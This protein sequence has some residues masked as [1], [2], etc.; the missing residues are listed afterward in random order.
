MKK[1]ITYLFAF[2]MLLLNSQKIIG[3]TFSQN[4]NLINVVPLLDDNVFENSEKFS[5]TLN[6]YSIESFVVNDEAIVNLENEKNLI[7]SSVS[8]VELSAP[9]AILT[10]ITQA[11][12]QTAVD[13]WIANP[14]TATATYGHISNWDTSN[15]T[16]MSSLFLNKTTFNDDI[17]GWD[18]SNVVSIRAMFNNAS[19]FNQ[20]IA[21]W[22]VSNVTGFDQVFSGATSF[23]QDIS[24]WNVAAS[25]NFKEM[26]KD[27][28]NFNQPLNNW[29]VTDTNNM[30]S[31]FRGATSFNQPLNN[32]NVTNITAMYFMFSGATNFN[33]DLTNW[34]ATNIASEP[35][36]FADNSALLNTNKPS[37]GTCTA[38]TS[39][40]TKVA[41]SITLNSVVLEGYITSNVTVIERGFVFAVTS[42]NSNPEINGTGVVKENNDAG[43]GTFSETITGLTSNTEYSYKAYAITAS[44]IIYGNVLT[45]TTLGNTP[46]VFTSVSSVN[47]T[48]NTDG[49][50]YTAEATDS[51]SITY[52][53]GVN[54]DESLF[55]IVGSTGE[56]SFVTSPDFETKASY[57]IN[58]IATDALGNAANKDVIIT[59]IDLDEVPPTFTSATAV[60][61][62]ENEAGVAYTITA[63]DNG[64]ITYN[65]GSGNDEASFTIDGAEV[66]F[67]A[68]PDFETKVSYTINVIAT[69]DLGNA[70]NQD[71]II[72]IIDLDEVP[73]TVV[74]TSSLMGPTSTTPIPVTVTFSET[75]TGFD[76][77]D[78][79]VS[80]GTIQSFTGTDA[81][82]SFDLVPSGG[83]TLTVDIAADV[84][85][86]A[87]G[88]NNTIANQFSIEYSDLPA[89]A[90]NF[91]GVD[92]Y[93]IIGNVLPSNTSYTKEAWIFTEQNKEAQNIISSL[94]APFWL[95]NL[96][97]EAT[98]LFR[99]SGSVQS[100]NTLPLNTWVHVAVSWDGTT[101]RLYENGVEV[102]SRTNVG[103]YTREAINL[104]AMVVGNPISMLDG[105]LDEV[106][107]WNTARS[108]A[109]IV[110]YKDVELTGN[111]SGL[112][113][114]YNFNQGNVNANNSGVTTLL[115][116]QTN[117]TVY[118]GTL[119][120]FTLTGST[121]NWI[122]GLANDVV[123][124]SL[125]LS[126]QAATDITTAN[127][128]LSG[129]VITVG[130]KSISEKGIMISDVN[131]NPTIPGA[132]TVKYIDTSAGNDISITRTD[133]NIAT[134]Y[135]FRTYA[136]D[137]DG[138][139]FYGDVF[140]FNTSG[141]TAPEIS[142]STATDITLNS[143]TL[144]GTIT[145]N[146]TKSIIETG[147]VI[148]ISSENA[149]P[150]ISGTDT[151]KLESGSISDE[152]ISFATGLSSNVQYSFK[153]YLIDED[154]TE[155]YGAV[156]TFTTPNIG[157]P[158]V[159]TTP[160]YDVEKNFATFGGNVLTNNGSSITAMG[161][162][163]SP[164][165]S[166]SNPQ[167]NGTDVQHRSKTP[168]GVG[169]FTLRAGSFSSGVQYS[170]RMYTTNAAGTAYSQVFT[171]YPQSS[172]V[173]T[174]DAINFTT[175][176][177]MLS[178]IVN[179]NYGSSITEKGVVYS[180]ASINNK[181]LING[182][183]V[184]KEPISDEVGGYFV[185]TINGLDVSTEY[186]FRTYAIN[187]FGTSYG[188]VKTFTTESTFLD[189]RIGYWTFEGGSVSDSEGNFGDLVFENADVSIVNGK[190]DVK[191]NGWARTS[192][193]VGSTIEE[194]TL[195]SF[196]EMRDLSVT[197]GA[198]IAIDGITNDNFDAIGFAERESGRWLAGS[199]SFSRTEDATPGFEETVTNIPV[200]M[201]IT[202]VRTP[203][204]IA[205]VKIYRNGEEIGAYYK[206]VFV[207]WPANNTEI[208]FGPRHSPTS[209]IRRG[210]IDALIDEAMLFNRALSPTEIRSLYK[211]SIEK[212]TITSTP[213]TLIDVTTV[214]LGGNITSDGKANVTER[215]IVYA[216]T[217]ANES[218]EIDGNEV[219]KVVGG[220]GIG[221][222][223]E[224]ITGLSGGTEY[225]YRSYAI[226]NQ[227]TAYG[228]VLTFSTLA[229]LAPSVTTTDVT[230]IEAF[231]A[232]FGSAVTNNG[233][234]DI[235][236]I[237]VL[238][239]ET[240]LNSNPEVTTTDVLKIGVEDAESFIS[241]IKN[242][243]PNTAYSYR[244]YANNDS[245]FGYGVTKTFTT[246]VVL[247][248]I[249]T[250]TAYEI[251]ETAA[252][253][254]IGV[255]SNGGSLF[256]EYG[257]VLSDVTLN[258]DPFVGGSNV[259]KITIDGID[260]PTSGLH[261]LVLTGLSSCIKYA[262]KG[263]AINAAG[264]T[265]GSLKTFTTQCP[266]PAGVA[267]ITTV[268]PQ[269]ITE[270]A[271][272]LAGNVS[273]NNGAA[274]TKR[275]IVYAKTSVNT[276][277]T[278][279][280]TDL[281]DVEL[282]NGIGAFNFKAIGLTP[283]TSYTYRAY[284]INSVGTVYGDVN[285]FTTT[286][287]PSAIPSGLIGHWDFENGSLEDKTG[288]WAALTLN[289][290][291]SIV[292]GKLDLNPGSLASTSTYA[293]ETIKQKTLV[294]FVELQ[295]L[296][297]RA[298]S[299][300]TIDGKNTTDN[301]D[302][303]VF[304][305]R[306]VNRWMAGS[307]WFRRTVNPT[308]GFEETTVG[309]PIMMAITYTEKSNG[310][311][312]I[313][314]YRNAVEIASYIKGNIAQWLPNNAEVL[315]G[316]RHT[317]PAMRG[318][319]DALVDEAMIFN[320][321]L[322]DAE[323]MTLYKN[324]VNTT[325]VV[326]TPVHSI[327]TNSAV[328][329]GNVL[330]DGGDTITDRGI[331]VAEK[332]INANPEIGGTGVTKSQI[333]EG[334]GFFGAKVSG[335][336]ESTTYA[337]KTYAKNS[338]GTVY[339]NVEEFSTIEVNADIAPDFSTAN[340]RLKFVQGQYFVAPADGVLLSISLRTHYA[341]KGS[342]LGRINISVYESN[343]DGSNIELGK[344][345]SFETQAGHMDVNQR[346]K[347]DMSSAGISLIR[348]KRYYYKFEIE[349]SAAGNKVIISDYAIYSFVTDRSHYTPG[350][351]IS[352]GTP[353]TESTTETSIF[354]IE[355]GPLRQSVD[356]IT[357]F[358]AG[359]SNDF[360]NP[361]N[362]SKGK[363][364]KNESIAVA[365]GVTLTVDQNDVELDDFFL[366]S[367]AELNIPN[368]KEV[369]VNS[370]F[371]TDGSLSLESSA[372][373]SGVLFLKGITTGTVT[374]KRGGL[375]A[376]KWSIIS[377][378]VSG[379][380]VIEFAQNTD[381]D[382]R[383]NNSVSPVR[384]AIGYYDDSMANKWQY[385]NA[386]TPVADT[387]EI[388][389]S[390]SMSRATDG[391]VTFT[392]TLEVGNVNQNVNVGEWQ[393]IGNPYTTYLAANKN[394][395][396]S[397]LEDNFDLLDDVF[398]GLYIWDNTQNK[399]VA[400][401]QIDTDNRSIPPGQGFFIR[402]KTSTNV[403]F[404]QN[405]R[406]LKP[407]EGNT[408]FNKSSNP[409]LVLNISDGIS[410]V[411]T[412]IKYFENATRA[413][414]AGYDFGNFGSSQLDIFTHLLEGNEGVDYTIQSLP[415]TDVDNISIPIGV[416]V[417]AG[418]E[419]VFSL[420]KIDIKD[421]LNIYL[422]DK[423]LNTFTS[424]SKKDEDYKISVSEDISGVGRF[425]LITSSKALN[426]DEY[427]FN[428][429][430]TVYTTDRNAL[431]ISGI[432]LGDKATIN[433][434][435]TL[436][437][438]VG[439]FKIN[440]AEIQNTFNLNNLPKGVY[441]VRLQSNRTSISK[442]IVLK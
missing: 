364:S 440:E 282:G 387:F 61:F 433:L 65:L 22:D 136:I 176:S 174:E 181:P 390:Y 199:T 243:K 246:N 207:G 226:N 372:E 435:N 421:G 222:F 220:T 130:S 132:A 32:W 345:K 442:K 363:P 292:D 354:G 416:S 100:P 409:E 75:I 438:Q 18:T 71:V 214:T 280:G 393:A 329:G 140:T 116:R 184:T 382:I 396:S 316:A 256:T 74:I 107:I 261:R 258:T 304:S 85:Q 86:D 338:S 108:S 149:D 331:V 380:R 84:A 343:S 52:S 191:S 386:D 231:K 422:E 81:D 79:S 357:T 95:N 80:G 12:I 430:I 340:Q 389:R 403:S 57:T 381:N 424:L 45:F 236:D 114:Y 257:I 398:K 273:A 294:S 374:Y 160:V 239:I 350:G 31:M 339:G 298:G 353:L 4:N 368:D 431:K 83:G 46:P 104:G 154:N 385:Y 275:G 137:A 120:D 204:G 105:N 391:E 301:F 201:A 206:G 158:T 283:S 264:T 97:L 349:K 151:T 420:S 30:Q 289:S 414:D 287:I 272:I 260:S 423:L 143:A 216:R 221:I 244:G 189:K 335:F 432:P 378:P 69:D 384:Y 127:A 40:D 271:A 182:T 224:N 377:A 311:V 164:T 249:T 437:K 270:N 200:M 1:T 336:E 68:S 263:Y 70:A 325:E 247:G 161:I 146:G 129:L 245:E 310:T 42:T 171:F 99:Y 128:T 112:V 126:T 240:A 101:M 118:N 36:G 303:I 306:Q 426:T 266:P 210:N 119:T 217:F 131:T 209:T 267:S 337:Y 300:L 58:V 417:K 196:V 92:D 265:Y 93:V 251:R 16:S 347:I 419:V 399:Y 351:F 234:A 38:N 47:F 237:G 73:P 415:L 167:L 54:A 242:L 64:V 268:A 163:F 250:T 324:S 262:Y 194:K 9:N 344:I 187:A 153:A 346:S 405:K 366:N 49:I 41:T 319:I 198:V 418:K 50:V 434:F 7:T 55:T 376:N 96:K 178:G 395:S 90:L 392:G 230:N 252:V 111:E 360:S 219:T 436:G 401:T 13:D 228:D 254:G 342:Y 227:G 406:Q 197:A 192:S 133:L 166:N 195:V 233:G 145:V 172:D 379:Q 370:E 212:A 255:N 3:Q 53:L 165:A 284:A 135:Y 33:Q 359:S 293:G 25:N 369:I 117:G 169:E 274:V 91:D 278:T 17:S 309:E 259:N 307:S 334:K 89:T 299:V 352:N 183:G 44:G 148:A 87:A 290:S 332:A 144:S 322:S 394:E 76:A 302:G 124:G 326:T 248:I 88:N 439:V 312:S 168:V 253:S 314:I 358:T 281:F 232:T 321:P 427:S 315:F 441:F 383:I 362:W 106:R 173:S 348:G 170:Y 238:L 66:S 277:P 367:G 23:N 371:N 355:V 113:A 276:L 308:P 35:I 28:I 179:D 72:T 408:T 229:P 225:S 39:V 286:A 175:T 333:G 155:Y 2:F 56:V 203:A 27:A 410:T 21:G 208:L 356:G 429:N 318:N 185:E 317:L 341:T 11:N 186:S 139:T 202:Y 59:I 177:A 77:G 213:A 6:D 402:T 37:W 125:I 147:F 365:N 205:N 152:F 373:S 15:I 235:E 361:A 428:K 279:G 67:V 43:S 103:N 115:D 110:A 142:T 297:A 215:G 291:T 29:D 138:K 60:D 20:N 122:D 313:R 193:Y 323:I 150:T 94:K 157:L 285:E 162:L 188:A 425:Y 413:F 328:F 320:R 327:G 295:D 180:I 123:S 388:G 141:H 218:P 375:L 10:P 8:K 26:F 159:T 34:C 48:E 400:V 397:F 51:D 134:Q 211:G 411:K 305:E 269:V 5:N 404:N 296:S 121:S 241:D 412:N 330:N 407:V 19:S 156:K 82:Y 288:N 102:D 109:E 63:T 98:N 190:L 223:T 14:T 24:S 62:T 78:I